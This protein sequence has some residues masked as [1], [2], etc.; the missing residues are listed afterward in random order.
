MGQFF[1]VRRFSSA[2]AF[3]ADGAHLLFASNISGQFNLWRVPV[4]GGWPDQLTAFTDETV[5]GVGVSPADGR[6]V[7]CADHDGDEFHQLYLLDSD[8][9]WPEKLTDEPQ[10]QHYVGSAAWSPDGTKFA[11]A[12]N[13][14]KPTDMEVWVRD[15][16]SGGTR[17]VFGEGMFSFP[18]RFSPDGSKLLTLDFRNNSD[19]SIHLVDLETGETRELT[20]HDD[21][22]IFFS[23]PWAPDGSGFYML[24]DAGSEF[25]GLAFY[26]LASDRYEWVEEPTQDVDD[27]TVSTDGRVLAW[28][29]NDNGYDRLRLRDLET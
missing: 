11:Y 1:A 23:G 6:I 3:S 8:R 28:L 13:A 12:A 19:A 10:V 24:T 20:P 5:R 16:E 17:P 21:E 22:A 2:L 18:G 4:E 7:L 29:M 15:I 27:V 26:D 25:R 14:R 9:G